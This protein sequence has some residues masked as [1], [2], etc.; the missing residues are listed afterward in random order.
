MLYIVSTTGNCNLACTYCGGSVSEGSMPREVEY[1][2]EALRELVAKDDEATIAFYGGEPL[3]R[4]PLIRDIMDRVG[5]KRFVLQTNGLLLHH[6]PQAYLH[7][8]DAILVSLDGRPQVTDSHRG[9]GLQQKVIAQVRK[10]SGGYSGDL[11]ARMTVTEDSDIYEEVTHLLSMGFDHVHWQL[12]AIW[13]PEGSWT[14]FARWVEDRYNPGVT[15]LK[16][17][18]LREMTQGK[19]LGIVPFQGIMTRLHS[20]LSGL[21]CGAGRDAFAITTDGWILGCPIGPEYDWNRIGRLGKVGPADIKDRLEIDG[22]C[23][24]CDVADVCGGRCL[25]ANREGHWEQDQFDIV[26][27]TVKHVVREMAD[28]L[29]KVDALVAAGI[30]TRHQLDYPPFNNT[31]EIIP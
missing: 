3:L 31:T 4:I 8:F 25:F 10:I 19:V 26:C 13:S 14:D 12:N 18:W 9:R 11:I 17:L 2:V 15:R 1:D 16:E 6:A 28:S 7:R 30:V 27:R 23:R 24:T 22:A 21:P 20:G 29:P 5:A